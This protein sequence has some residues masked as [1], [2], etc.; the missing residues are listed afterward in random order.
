MDVFLVLK[1]MEIL[2]T[3]HTLLSCP[4]TDRKHYHDKAVR[5]IS[6]SL[7]PMPYVEA[8]LN[9][10]IA[11]RSEGGLEIASAILSDSDE[12]AVISLIYAIRLRSQDVQRW[13]ETPEFRYHRNDDAW[14]VLLRAASRVRG[15]DQRA[16]YFF[17][18]KSCLSAH[19]RGLREAVVD[20]LQALA[21][22]DA[23]DLLDHLAS[24]DPDPLIARMAREAA[25]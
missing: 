25:L 22:K 19:N 7:D 3:V 1:L 21:T 18:L 12:L 6:V 5:M 14:T 24:L 2:Q 15:Q 11:V 8:I 20:G 4:H 10:C 16:D 17:L 9:L 13:S 23:K